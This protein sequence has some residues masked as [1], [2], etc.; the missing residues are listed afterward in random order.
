MGTP[1]TRIEPDR[2]AVPA[3]DAAALLGI[4]RAQLWKLHSAGKIPLP[5]RLG[6]RAPRWIVAELKAWLAADAP[7][8]QEWERTRGDRQ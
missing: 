4:S 3:K 7:D 8:R 6:T 5:V 1:T 2:H